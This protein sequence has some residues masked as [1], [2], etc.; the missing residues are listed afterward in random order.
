MRFHTRT[1]AAARALGA[2]LALATLAVPALLALLFPS[3]A[4]AL[5]PLALMLPFATMGLL[6]AALPS[7]RRSAGSH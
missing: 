4:D 5:V 2:G 7:G 6:E 1:M 3:H